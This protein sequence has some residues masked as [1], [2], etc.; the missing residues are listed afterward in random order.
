MEKKEIKP[1]YATSYELTKNILQN[2][3]ARTWI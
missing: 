1:S 3:L 2:I